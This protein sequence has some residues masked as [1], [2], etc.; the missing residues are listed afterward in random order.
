MPQGVVV[1]D[2]ARLDPAGLDR[3]AAQ[4]QDEVGTALGYFHDDHRGVLAVVLH[5]S[6]HPGA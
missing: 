3:T 2:L 4:A 1:A 5:L 6:R